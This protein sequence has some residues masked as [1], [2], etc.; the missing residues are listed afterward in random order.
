MTI[1]QLNLDD[2]SFQELVSEARMRIARS[3][4]EWTEHNV[5]D[6]GI[7]LIELFAWMTD[8]L[9]YRLNRVPDKI[10]LALLELLGI[11]LAPPEAAETTVRFWLAAPA[12]QPVVIPARETEVA[13]PRTAGEDPLV[14]QTSDDFVIRPVRPAA[15]VVQ[16][17]GTIVEMPV[18]DG[19]ARPYGDR[20]QVFASSPAADDS[21]Y[22][23]FEEPLGRLLL[24]VDVDCSPARGAGVHPEE[25]PLVWE[26]SQHNGGWEEAEVLAD[27][28]GGFNYGSGSVEL[29][30]P[31]RSAIIDVSGRR[32]YWLRCRLLDKTRTGAD[33]AGYSHPPEVT[34]VTARAVG[35]QLPAS[36]S[37]RET[38]ESLGYSD[39]TAAQTL[40]LRHAPALPLD[41]THEVLE[42]N[43]PQTGH[44]HRWEQRESFASSG[45]HDRHFVFDASVG[46]IELGPAIRQRDGSWMQHGMIPPK[47]SALRIT[48]YR[49]GGGR[50]G[51][52][53]AQSLTVL[54]TSIPGVAAVTNPE[55]AHGGVDLESLT[56]ARRRAMLELRTR[57][58]AVTAADFE[59]LALEAS[60]RVGRAKCIEPAATEAVAVYVLEALDAADRALTVDEVT[61][62]T[63]VLR[64]IA[65][66]L[67]ERRTVG[68][69][70]HVRPVPLRGVSVEVELEAAPLTDPG[71]VEV[72]VRQALYRYLNPLFGEAGDDEAQDGWPFGRPVSEGELHGVVQ[73]VDGVELI[74][75]LQIY[76]TDPKTSR[77]APTPAIGRL[78]LRPEE[79]VISINHVVKAVRAQRK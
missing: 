67:D 27:T 70:V 24:K 44:W 51:N 52:V 3:C 64:E 1:P 16:H 54:R 20:Q 57:Y 40:Q 8:M 22:L 14:F 29:Q 61:P 73:S 49:H 56:V 30:L 69:V 46:Q 78:M 39:G 7:T 47:G 35:A 77:R 58:R 19:D 34:R 45:P 62:S 21:L 66:Y 6:P 79:L 43:D 48:G 26:V 4:P 31:G 17:S 74:S 60:P 53:A 75:V 18:A 12:E 23:G 59:Y 55:P 2:R 15:C 71:R 25:P 32:L 63:A 36:H 37:A 65:S 42:V 50:R 9:V 41:P 38:E 33:T 10:H 76:E 68:T 72:D 5:S 11:Q 13:T 28:T